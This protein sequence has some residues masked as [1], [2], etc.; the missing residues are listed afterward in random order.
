[1]RIALIST[2]QTV[3]DKDLLRE[4]KRR[5][6]QL[7]IFQINQLPLSSSEKINISFSDFDLIYWRIGNP[8]IRQIIALRV[9][10]NGIPFINSGYWRYPLLGEKSYQI[11]RVSLLGIKVPKT[12]L[13]DAEKYQFSELKK[14]LGLPLILK[15]NIGAMGK[16]VWLI[17]NGAEIKKIIKTFSL[18]EFLAQKFLPNNG[19]YR[20]LVVG[21]KAIGVFK[22]IPKNGEFKANIALGGHGEKVENKKISNYLK[23]LAEKIC[24]ALGLEI[25]GIDFIESRK[26]F[27]FIESNSIVQWQGFQK[28]T[29]INVAKKIFD[30]FE[31]IK[32]GSH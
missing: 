7:I 5:N 24:Q 4:A 6:H 26:E 15:K 23:L 2:G 21:K 12:Y 19:D 11:Y 1:M 22:R 14:N 25:A 9:T 28:T 16:N 27:Y 17:N 13:I 8:K 18:K 32:S 10:R 31:Q 20:V 30:Y 29:K 3:Q